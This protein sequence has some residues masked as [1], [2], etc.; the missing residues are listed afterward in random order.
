MNS[1]CDWDESCCI[2]ISNC[3]LPER[4][5]NRFKDKSEI[6]R[7]DSNRLEGRGWSWRVSVWLVSRWSPWLAD[8][9]LLYV[10]SELHNY[11]HTF[12]TSCKKSWIRSKKLNELSRFT[13]A[14][15]AQSDSC[16]ATISDICLLDILGISLDSH[17]CTLHLLQLFQRTTGMNKACSSKN[18]QFLES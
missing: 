17:I 9:L 3:Q 16:T 5:L 7:M 6:S 4:W 8:L 14:P 13:S 12:V 1:T 18:R 10:E 2:S 11:G 15:F